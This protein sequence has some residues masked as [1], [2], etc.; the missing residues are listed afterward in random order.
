MSRT[1]Q[2]G[3]RT[4]MPDLTERQR[5]EAGELAQ[6]C[7]LARRNSLQPIPPGLIPVG[8]WIRVS[9]GDQTEALQIPDVMRYCAE[10]GYYVIRCYALNDKSAFKGEQ[11]AKQDEALA[12]TRAGIIK[13]LVIWASDRIERQGAEASLRIVRLFREAGGGLESTKELWLGGAD[14]DLMVAVTGWKD[15]QESLRKRDRTLIAFAQSEANGAIHRVAPYGYLITG[16]K[17]YKTFAVNFDDDVT[18]VDILADDYRGTGPAAII[19]EAFRRYEAGDTIDAIC[20]DFDARGIP[21][22]PYGKRGPGKHWYPKV[23]SLMLRNI[24]YTGRILDPSG[25]RTIARVP[26]LVTLK[27][28]NAVVARLNKRGHRRGIP[29]DKGNTALLTSVISCKRCG[30][31]QYKFKTGTPSAFNEDGSPMRNPDGT[32]IGTSLYYYCRTKGCKMIPLY[33]LHAEFERHLHTVIA[34][35]VIEREVI[36]PGH[37]HDDEIEHV[38]LDI[39]ALD[40]LAADYGARHA[41]CLAELARL[42]ELPAVADKREVVKVTGAEIL[43]PWDRLDT[44]GKRQLL[45]G[46]GLRLAV[47]RDEGGQIVMQPLTYKPVA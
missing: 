23:L 15:N 7:E 36:T 24:A 12:D 17:Y 27:R 4:S 43:A 19:Q 38:A 37:N 46:L 44:P 20:L 26:A 28:Y 3:S 8:V 39:R 25:E 30:R 31:P 6:T 2:P 40:P 34:G 45:L 5:A 29:T 35:Q 10:R 42:R 11:E 18:D 41:A 21:S 14:T 13:V 16:E 9:S 32:P 1:S 47:T 22:P 33:A